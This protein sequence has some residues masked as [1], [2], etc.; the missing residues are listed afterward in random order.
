MRYVFFI[1][2]AAGKGKAQEALVPAVE[3]YFKGKEANY[4]IIFTKAPGDALERAR[5]EAEKGDEVTMFACGGDGTFFEVLNGVYKYNNVILGVIPCGSG[6]DFLKTFETTEPFS[7]V[8]SQ[9]EGVAV[10]MDAILV[11]DICCM[12]ICSLG[13]DA[14]VADDMTIFK[15]WPLV[16]GSMAYKLAIV[17]T[18][19]RKLG[20][21]IKVKID[22][23]LLGTYN[24]LFAVCGNGTTYGGGYRSCPRANPSD[25]KLEWLIVEKISKLKILAFLKTYERGEH[26]DLPFVKSGQCECMELEAECDSPINIDG[27]IIHKKSVCFKILKNA[28]RVILPKGVYENYDKKCLVTAE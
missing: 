5:E 18:F 22:G 26:E 2:P 17:K 1:N 6:N 20:V 13:M 3:E 24:C 25:G 19:L 27:E 15:K 14:I 4:E 10:P 11:D 21:N 23:V 16:S 9:M 12:N 8:E 7:N 28:V